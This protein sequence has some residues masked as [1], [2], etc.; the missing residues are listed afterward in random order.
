[1]EL[2]I[3][4]LAKSASDLAAADWLEQ[5]LADAKAFG[6][7]VTGQLPRDDGGG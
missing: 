2:A 6:R 5:F 7:R 1:M 3:H 4:V